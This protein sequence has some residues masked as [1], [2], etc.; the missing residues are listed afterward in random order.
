MVTLPERNISVPVPPIV[1]RH[2]TWKK[3][4]QPAG[5]GRWKVSRVDPLVTKNICTKYKA[6]EGCWSISV[7]TNVVNW[8]TGIA[9]SR[10]TNQE[11]LQLHF[12]PTVCTY[13]LYLYSLTL[14]V[15]SVCIVCIWVV[16]TPE[17]NIAYLQY[18]AC[19][20]A[21]VL[22]SRTNIAVTIP[23]P[24]QYNKEKAQE[25]LITLAVNSAGL[26]SLC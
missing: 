21:T 25:R 4:C 10:A 8:A 5:V 15:L 23:P 9:I 14:T 6:S 1:L 2:F 7:W 11:K 17:N 19:T 24:K 20:K 3:K 18:T 12:R 22:F 13:I 16:I 26:I